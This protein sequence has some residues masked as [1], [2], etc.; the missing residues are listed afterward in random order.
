M[1][2]TGNRVVRGLLMGL[3]AVALGGCGGATVKVGVSVAGEGK[4]TSPAGLDCGTRCEATIKLQGSPVA[5]GSVAL[6][7][8]AQTGSRLLGW[9]RADCGRENSCTLA[10]E[11]YCA[12]GT[13]PLPGCAVWDTNRYDI[14]PVFV[15]TADV[16]SQA[17]SPYSVC[18]IYHTG[19]LR[20]WNEFGV[21][22][23]VPPVSN[24]LQVVTEKSISCVEDDSGVQCWGAHTRPTY[25]CPPGTLPPSDECEVIPPE[26]APLP[27]LYPPLTL[28]AGGG[29]AC[30]LDL[31]GVKCWSG[32]GD[33]QVPALNDPQNLRTEN[34]QI[35]VDDGGEKVCWK[36]D[37]TLLQGG[38][39]NGDGI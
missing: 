21:D 38:Q 29:F 20:C 32:F 37:Y 26:V 22:P 23:Q 5:T 3:V 24:P 33:T 18:A 34:R 16:A 17:W 13:S 30:A 27:A 28:A 35:C 2:V 7:A 11:Q 4:V 31:E 19:E 15:R 25:I 12:I 10:L 39:G 8:I 1:K 14:K 9:N 36:K 6:T